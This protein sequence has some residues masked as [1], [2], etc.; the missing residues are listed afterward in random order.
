MPQLEALLNKFAEA[1][2]PL[3]DAPPPNL[4]KFYN[5]GLKGKV[6]ELS[7]VSPLV[8]TGKRAEAVLVCLNR[9]E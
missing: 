6:K 8:R 3:L 5:S 9:S 2:A 4:N 1:I 7:A